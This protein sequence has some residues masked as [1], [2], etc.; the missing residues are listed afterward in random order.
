MD[1]YV[2]NITQSAENQIRNIRN[3]IVNE[4]HTLEHANRF[5]DFLENEI[6]TLSQLPQR[7]VLIDEEPW[8]SKG[9]R[10]MVIKNFIVYFW[11]DETKKIVQVLM[12]VYKKRNQ[13]KQLLKI[14]VK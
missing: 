8:R 7:I 12:V 9:I 10:K 2:I 6:N 4:L 11:I 5:L 14:N 13:V 3:Y 1:L